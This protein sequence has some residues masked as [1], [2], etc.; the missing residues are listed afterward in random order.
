[1]SSNALG[2]DG[3]MHN[4]T[5]DLPF[6]VTQYLSNFVDAP[7]NADS[8]GN[9]EAKIPHHEAIDRIRKA[10]NDIAAAFADMGSFGVTLKVRL[11]I[12]AC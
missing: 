11:T 7:R 6:L 12:F 5:R 4:P 3:E 1:M 2:M 9:E 8:K 10:T